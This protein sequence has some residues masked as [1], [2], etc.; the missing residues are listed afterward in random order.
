MQIGDALGRAVTIGNLGPREIRPRS[1]S[2]HG[3]HDSV[4]DRLG[5]SWKADLGDFS[6]APKACG[7]RGLGMHCRAVTRLT[8]EVR[9]VHSAQMATCALADALVKVILA[10][11]PEPP[12]NVLDQATSRVMRRLRSRLLEKSS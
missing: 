7:N 11:L 4:A 2:S 12:G 10:C 5:Q 9:A 8:K 1:P 6:R 3:G